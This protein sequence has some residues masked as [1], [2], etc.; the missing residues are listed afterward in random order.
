[1]DAT[2]REMVTANLKEIHRLIDET[3]GL[4]DGL[5]AVIVL[6]EVTANIY[7]VDCADGDAERSFLPVFAEEEL[8]FRAD[9]LGRGPKHWV[10]TLRNRSKELTGGTVM[11]GCFVRPEE[12]TP[13]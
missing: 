5:A 7:G 6:D 4:R 1:M 8:G 9:L 3:F 12:G 13:A 11:M 10:L 2:D